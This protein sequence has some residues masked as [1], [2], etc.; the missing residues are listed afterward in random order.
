MYPSLEEIREYMDRNTGKLLVLWEYCHAMGNGPG[1]F[2][3]Y[4][5][6]WRSMKESAEGLYGNGAIMPFTREEARRV[7]LCIFTVGIMGNFLTMVISA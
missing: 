3:D 4:F 1:D 7:S 2:E 5:R 6:S